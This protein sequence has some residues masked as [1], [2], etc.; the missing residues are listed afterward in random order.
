MGFMPNSP[1][2]CLSFSS[3]DGSDYDW[4]VLDL[5]IPMTVQRVKLWKINAKNLHIL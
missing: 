5:V 1:H 2:D 3:E 4:F